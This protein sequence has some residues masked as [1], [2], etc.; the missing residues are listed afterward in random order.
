MGKEPKDEQP[1]ALVKAF[2]ASTEFDRWDVRE[3]GGRLAT[4]IAA[5]F[6][7]K[8]FWPGLQTLGFPLTPALRAVVSSCAEEI[9]AQAKD[10]MH[11]ALAIALEREK[12]ELRARLAELEGNG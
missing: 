5:D 6:E 2:L 11:K 7:T 1:D 3:Y 8:D 9:L 12:A 10:V 4:A